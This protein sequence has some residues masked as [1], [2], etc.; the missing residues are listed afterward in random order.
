[1]WKRTTRPIS[2]SQAG[3]SSV[4]PRGIACS[5]THSIRMFASFTPGTE[6]TSLSTGVSFANSISL[7]SGGRLAAVSLIAST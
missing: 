5:N 1:M 7:S 2:R 3:A 4:P 6:M